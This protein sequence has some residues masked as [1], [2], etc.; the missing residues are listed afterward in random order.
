MGRHSTDAGAYEVT[1]LPSQVQ[2]AVCHGFFVKEESRGKKKSHE[3]KQHQI[4]LLNELGYD[5]AICTVAAGNHKQ[6]TVLSRAGW[7]CV[8]SFYNTRLSERTELWTK[9]IQ[10]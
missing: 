3:L 10:P 6:K 1:S 9:H 7:R 5:L 2:I 4:D 8:E